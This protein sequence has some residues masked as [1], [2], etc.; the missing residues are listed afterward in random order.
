MKTTK[1][2]VKF[3]KIAYNVYNYPAGVI[4][5]FSHLLACIITRTPNNGLSALHFEIDKENYYQLSAYVKFEFNLSKFLY[6][7]ISFSQIIVLLL[8]LLFGVLF[9]NVYLLSFGVY[10]LTCV[11]AYPSSVDI[12][13]FR[14]H[15]GWKKYT[16][17][18]RKN[19]ERD[20][21]YGTDENYI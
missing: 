10:L 8:V 18:N 5:E 21:L 7:F 6:F 15:K 19:L 1:L 12:G 13:F 16:I 2:F 14:N 20:L 11:S 4:H 17:E 9:L 3:L